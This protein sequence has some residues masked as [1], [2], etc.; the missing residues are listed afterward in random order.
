VTPSAHEVLTDLHITLWREVIAQRERA[1]R[2][3]E[4]CRELEA[5]LAEREGGE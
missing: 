5:L 4:R 1:E 2:A 3:E